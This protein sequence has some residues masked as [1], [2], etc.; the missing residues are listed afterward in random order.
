MIG[1]VTHANLV[2]G[3]GGWCSGIRMPH[4]GNAK[5]GD[6]LQGTHV[7]A[8]PRAESENQAPLRGRCLGMRGAGL[9]PRA[10]PRPG[11][12]NNTGTFRMCV[13]P[14]GAKAAVDTHASLLDLSNPMGRVRGSSGSVVEEVRLLEQG[15][16]AD[17]SKVRTVQL[18][19]TF[20]CFE[21]SA[22]PTLWA[23]IDHLVSLRFLGS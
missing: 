17:A 12:R 16:L 7:S 2:S 18:L 10:S 1:F 21:G 5:V 23:R 3:A 8:T 19:I 20:F 15:D 22:T 11:Q 4:A 13:C 9:C 6:P 14:C